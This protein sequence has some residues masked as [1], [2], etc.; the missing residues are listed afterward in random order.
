[1]YRIE[2]MSIADF[3]EVTRLWQNTEGVGL[4]EADSRE[5]LNRFLQR[6]PGMSFVARQGNEIVGAVLCGQDGRRG[7]LHHLAVATAHRNKGL[8]K[9]L[10]EAACSEVARANITRCNI[11]LFAEN[12]K[13]AQF[14]ARHGWTKR[15]DMVVMQKPLTEAAAQQIQLRA[16]E[17]R[18][19]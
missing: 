7:Y 12:E 17:H 6:N 14:W 8:G 19:T 2:P 9:R 13:G 15:D 5:N 11:Y 1:M 16:S 4:N 3:E 18:R 10:I